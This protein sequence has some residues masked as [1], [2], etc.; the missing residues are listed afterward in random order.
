V[1]AHRVSYVYIERVDLKIL[2]DLPPW[3]WPESATTTL[4]QVLADTTGDPNDRRLATELAGE[5]VAIDDQLAEALLTVVTD[6]TALDTLRARAAVA[7]GPVIEQADCDGFDDPDEPPIS[8]S[9]FLKL[10]DTLRAVYQDT[11]AAQEVRRRALESAVRAPQDWQAAAI[12]TAFSDPDT[13]WQLTA[14]FCM[15]FVRGF[16]A[17]I[18]AALGSANVEIRCEAVLAAG[19]WEVAEAYQQV[20]AL[21]RSPTSD[22]ALL[23]A[24]I[25]SAPNIRPEEAAELLSELLESPDEDIALAAEEALSMASLHSLDG[26][27]E[28]V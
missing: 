25:E 9:T 1:L 17:E 7:L 14:A 8:Q 27:D 19:T 28:A 13:G 10:C 6:R 18:V 15:R 20:A 23:L 21:I 3:E 22:K 4:L 26:D 24:A 16:A 5:S 2:Q 11:S 12:R